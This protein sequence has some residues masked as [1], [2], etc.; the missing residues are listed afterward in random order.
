MPVPHVYASCR[1][2]LRVINWAVTEVTLLHVQVIADRKVLGRRSF[3]LGV[4]SLTLHLCI[5]FPKM[6]E[7]GISS[8]LCILTSYFPKHHHSRTEKKEI[9]ESVFRQTTGL[10]FTL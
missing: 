1:R 4:K 7:L 3:R 10:P 2:S 8:N 6:V 9:V 5:Y